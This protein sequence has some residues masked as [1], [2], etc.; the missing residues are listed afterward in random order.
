MNDAEN[1]HLDTDYE[2][3][4]ESLKL[5]ILEHKKHKFSKGWVLLDF[6]T[7]EHQAKLL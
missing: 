5:K 6:P 4:T 1:F 7:T 3:L 2:N